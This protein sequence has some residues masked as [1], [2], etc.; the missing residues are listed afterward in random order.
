[1][2][3]AATAIL[4]A[5]ALVGHTAL[6]IGALNRSHGLGVWR[7]IVHACTAVSL[8]A[9]AAGPLCFV[10]AMAALVPSF[11]AWLPPALRSPLDM[12]GSRVGLIAALVY[13]GTCGLIAVGPFRAWLWSRL[14]PRRAACVLANHTTP[15]DLDKRLD[16][17]ARAAGIGRL[18]AALPGNEMLCLDTNDKTLALPRL[19]PALD[20]LSIAHLSDLHFTG[21]VGLG[22][23]QEVIER[24]NSLEP[25]LVA[26]TGDIID[27]AS[28]LDW[29]EETLGRLRARYGVYYVLGN[30]DLRVDI[31]TLR[32][33]LDD[34]GLVDLG[35]RWLELD[36]LGESIVL[37]GNEFPWLRPAPD[38]GECRRATGGRAPLRILLSHTPDQIAWARRH[39]FDLMLAGHTHGGQF[40]LPLLGP[41]LAPSL[42]GTRYAAGTF[43]E[44]PTVLH[45]SR[46][47]SSLTP[48]RFRCRPE[49]A[50]LTLVPAASKG[51]TLHHAC[52]AQGW[53]PLG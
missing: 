41:V 53:Q 9:L 50:K 24:T 19:P 25:D 16:R 43:D 18:L 7:P 52:E 39:D 6:W 14:W 40:T 42:Y 30:H 11:G 1:M 31:P 26:I 27:R 13:A 20:G 51:T 17:N 4:L 32:Q 38:I 46:G 10:V 3:S 23:F 37:A 8:V 49:L 29:I 35:G 12:A 34:C 2:A 22:F 45:V 47:L 28:C 36:V 48:L 44:P 33:R 15:L 21:R 5:L